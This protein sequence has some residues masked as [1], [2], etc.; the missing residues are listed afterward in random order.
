[1]SLK[2]LQLAPVHLLGTLLIAARR[3][4]CGIQIRRIPCLFA[5]RQ[6]TYSRNS[7]LYIQASLKAVSYVLS[8]LAVS[9]I[10]ALYSCEMTHTATVTI[11]VATH[12]IRR[13]RSAHR[14]SITSKIR[15]WYMGRHHK[16]S[17]AQ[18]IFISLTTRTPDV[19]LAFTTAI[20]IYLYFYRV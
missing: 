3:H 14:T 10:T 2:L 9:D 6:H 8:R 12:L 16:A 5:A 15:L 11:L 1:M 20:V 19:P 7:L 13:S 18:S 4:Q 17:L